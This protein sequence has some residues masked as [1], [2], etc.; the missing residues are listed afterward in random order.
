[1]IKK[2]LQTFYKIHILI[3]VPIKVQHFTTKLYVIANSTNT[4]TLSH[5]FSVCEFQNM[6][7]DGMR[8]AS[9]TAL[10]QY[11]I[12]SVL[13]ALSFD[14]FQIWAVEAFAIFHL[15]HLKRVSQQAG[16]SSKKSPALPLHTKD[17]N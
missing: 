16:L 12:L 6:M 14:I 7:N 3:F 5:D 1:M 15:F 8:L 9:N 17:R 2:Q 10:K 11:S 13:K 4:R